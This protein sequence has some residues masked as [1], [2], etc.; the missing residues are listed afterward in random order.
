MNLI[1]KYERCPAK[2]HQPHLEVW[3]N[4]LES[5]RFKKHTNS[6]PKYGAAKSKLPS[7][8]RTLGDRYSLGGILAEVYRIHTGNLKWVCGYNGYCVTIPPKMREFTSQFYLPEPI[9]L[10]AFDIQPRDISLIE[11]TAHFIYR[12]DYDITKRYRW[13]TIKAMR[14]WFPTN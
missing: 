11:S 2:I 13:P 10:W 5:R 1:K 7:M 6:K 12:L 4:T 8:L 14:W 3:I 9:I